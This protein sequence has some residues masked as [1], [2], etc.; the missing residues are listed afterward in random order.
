MLS[1]QGYRSGMGLESKE[2]VLW[3]WIKEEYADSKGILKLNWNF[4]HIEIG[5]E[6]WNCRY[7]C[8]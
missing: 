2:K 4:N 6:S 8:P 3:V 5:L 1:A 7:C